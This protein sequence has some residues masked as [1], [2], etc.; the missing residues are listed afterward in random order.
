[1][2]NSIENLIKVCLGVMRKLLYLFLNDFSSEDIDLF[3]ERMH[4]VKTWCTSEFQR[5]GRNIQLLG[6]WKATE[7]RLFLLYAG[8]SVLKGIVSEEAYNH[9]LLLHFAMTILVSPSLN[10]EQSSFARNL[11]V[12]F[13]NTFET[14]YGEENLIFNVHSLI[15]LADDCDFF[16]AP[17]DTFACFT[18]ENA[19]GKLKR[20]LRGR[21]TVVAQLKGIRIRLR[22][23]LLKAAI[24]S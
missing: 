6:R 24:H 10:S 2:I 17:L 15:H 1:M 22:F 11:L 9:F 3:N 8:P 19:L 20:Q 18:F 14:L 13:V 12:R 16:E 7:L 23:N 21:R 4:K 5:R